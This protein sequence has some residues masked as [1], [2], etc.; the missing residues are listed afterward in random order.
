MQLA[1]AGQDLAPGTQKQ[2]GV[3][4]P[5]FAGRAFGEGAQEEKDPQFPGQLPEAGHQGA[6]NGLGRGGGV[7]GA[8]QTGEMLRQG[9][10]PGAPGGGRLNQG[11]GPG[12]V[13][14]QV[15]GGI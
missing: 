6:V 4:G 5:G 14:L 12:Q 8:P 15:R 2:A 11:L 13:G 9:H 7:G 3:V 1:V 10:Q